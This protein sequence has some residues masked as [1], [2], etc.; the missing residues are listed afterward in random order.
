MENSDH[1]LARSN[2]YLKFAD[3]TTNSRDI[4]FHN[5]QY[6]DALYRLAQLC[7]AHKKNLLNDD[8]IIYRPERQTIAAE[9]LKFIT[10][11]QNQTKLDYDK[12]SADERIIIGHLVDF[13]TSKSPDIDLHEDILKAQ[14]RMEGRFST[15]NL[16]KPPAEAKEM[17]KLMYQADRALSLMVEKL[18]PPQTN[19]DPSIR[20]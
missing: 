1:Q 3:T 8:N 10:D 6:P 2:T 12:F 4:L 13:A 9:A 15:V 7:V 20:L 11:R 5:Q 18:T 17:L 16:L 14:G 19:P